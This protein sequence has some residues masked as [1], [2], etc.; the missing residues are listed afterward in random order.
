MKE[1][2]LKRFAPYNL[3]LAKTI[4]RTLALKRGIKNAKF[5]VFHDN[6]GEGIQASIFKRFYWWEDEC[7]KLIKKKFGISIIKK[8]FKKL[9]IDAKNIPDSEAKKVLKNKDVN[10]VGVSGKAMKSAGKLFI[11]LKRAI[12]K[13]DNVVGV[14]MNCLNE[15]YYIK[16]LNDKCFFDFK[17]K[18]R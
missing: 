1:E 5:L 17:I 4:C 8:S 13:E 7:T 18:E 6:P 2:G 3:R 11:A 10:A 14:G 9:G 16:K 12:D 15:S